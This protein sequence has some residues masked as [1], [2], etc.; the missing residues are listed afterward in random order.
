MPSIVRGFSFE[1][2]FKSGATLT[3]TDCTQDASLKLAI[4]E[5]MKQMIDD[6][7]PSVGAVALLVTGSLGVSPLK[8]VG[9]LVASINIKGDASDISVLETTLDL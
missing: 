7:V 3:T 8:P 2:E 4:A 5:A 6:L 1:V 9:G